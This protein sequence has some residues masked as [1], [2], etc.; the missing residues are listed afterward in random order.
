MWVRALDLVKE[1][2]T[3]GRM[4]V[5]AAFSEATAQ[6]GVA[7]SWRQGETCPPSASSGTRVIRMC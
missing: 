4:A 5:Q 1:L 7:A 3:K 6:A 2:N